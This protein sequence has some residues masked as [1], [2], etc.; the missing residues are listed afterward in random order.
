MFS[1]P[2]CS[3]EVQVIKTG[4]IKT[5]KLVTSVLKE[6][7]SEPQEINAGVQIR[8]HIFPIIFFSFVWELIQT[9]NCKLNIWVHHDCFF[10]FLRFRRFSHQCTKLSDTYNF[11]H[12]TIL[13]GYLRCVFVCQWMYVS[14]ALV[15][16][17]PTNHSVAKLVRHFT[18]M[19]KLFCYKDVQQAE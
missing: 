15:I 19:H 17:W 16:N 8:L 3:H 6:N 12:N 14:A 1:S 18:L 10:F 2:L 4:N 5:F 11:I 13:N 9:L 7:P